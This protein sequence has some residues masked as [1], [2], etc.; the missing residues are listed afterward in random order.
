MTE[1]GKY[2]KR[3]FQCNQYNQYNDYEKKQN[4]VCVNCGSNDIYE[5]TQNDRIEYILNLI[6]EEVKK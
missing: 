4:N 1:E 3:C 5:L 2:I 6:L